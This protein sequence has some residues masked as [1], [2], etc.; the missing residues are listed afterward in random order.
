MIKNLTF[1]NNLW[2]NYRIARAAVRYGHHK[3]ALHIFNNLTEQ[4]SS[5][6]LHFYLVSL[7]ELCEGEAQLIN[8]GET[9]KNIVERLD[10]AIVHYNKAL[11]A[12]KAASTPS[13]N[14]QFQS[15]YMRIRVEFLQSLLQ[16]IHTCNILCIVPPPAIASTIAQST[17]DEY[18]RHG[19]IT[20]QMRKCVKEF[21]NC[22][23]LYWKLYQTA[24]DAD[25]STLENIQMLQQMCALV[26]KC[27]ESVCVNNTM[28]R[29]E[30]VTFSTQN[31]KLECRQLVQA[32]Q[33]AAN[34]VQAVNQET[35]LQTITH[36]HVELLKTVVEILANASLSFPRFFFQVLQSTSVK[37]AISPQPRVL[38]EFIS[39]QAGSQLA[40]KVEGV[41]QHGQRPGLYRRVEEVI[42]TVTSQLQANNKNKE[43]D[44]RV[45]SVNIVDNLN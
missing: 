16:L 14:L 32:C 15:E 36:K 41:I 30:P 40:V 25:P 3:I 23:D 33:N 7:K 27:I 35:L 43:I 11:A 24:F 45:S 2:A 13:H 42:V 5:E 19:Y 1:N 34:I 38:G 17:R 22:S 8:D 6:H 18:Q 31:T 37:L 10:Y 28:V 9:S 4:V 12:L 21:N 29:D 26:E 44:T 39:V 20:N